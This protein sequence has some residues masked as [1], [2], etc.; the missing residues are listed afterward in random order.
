MSFSFVSNGNKALL[1]LTFGEP[2]GCTKNSAGFSVVFP[3]IA[4]D[5][6]LKLITKFLAKLNLRHV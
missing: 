6:K 5:I 3:E 4:R 2:S 1:T